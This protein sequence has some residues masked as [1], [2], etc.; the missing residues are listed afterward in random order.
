MNG[1][2]LE[3]MI[4]FGS[5]ARQENDSDSDYDVLVIIREEPDWITRENLCA[6]IRKDMAKEDINIDI[7]I[8]SLN[9][10][11]TVQDEQ[12]NVINT[13]IEEGIEM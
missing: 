6:K 4:L 5:R 11:A 3:K 8:R 9:Y 10:V 2:T 1:Y 13:A 7:L 12:G